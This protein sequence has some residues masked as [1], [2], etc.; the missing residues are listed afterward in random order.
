MLLCSVICF[1]TGWVL[2]KGL[3]EVFVKSY[4]RHLILTVRHSTVFE[5]QVE[6]C[7]Q[8]DPGEENL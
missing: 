6:S 4:C 3:V 7:H 5:L 8:N 1:L 2:R